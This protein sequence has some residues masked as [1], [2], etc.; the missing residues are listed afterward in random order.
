ML[1]ALPG[2][3]KLTANWVMGELSAALNKE[4]L[5]IGAT[6]LD[7]GRLAR[8]LARIAHGTISGK[9]AKEV[10]EE[11]MGGRRREETM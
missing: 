11:M 1:A 3:E 2:H 10:F 5:E 6:R 7:A 8:L 9:I 4:N